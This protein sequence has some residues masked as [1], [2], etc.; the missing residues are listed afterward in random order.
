MQDQASFQCTPQLLDVILP[1]MKANSDKDMS[2]FIV[3]EVF[4]TSLKNLIELGEKS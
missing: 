1:K 3:M 2:V 4:G